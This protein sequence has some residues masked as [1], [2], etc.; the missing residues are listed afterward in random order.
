MALTRRRVTTGVLAGAGLLALASAGGS[1][2]GAL[3]AARRRVAGRTVIADTP[4]GPI[5][6]AVAGRGPPLLMLHGT[7]GG[8]D[9]GLL[10]SAGLVARGF[11][12]I[13]PSRFGYLGTPLPQ[14]SG[15]AAEA[16]A[17][18]DLLDHLGIDRV[19]VAGASAGVLPAIQVALRHPERCTRLVLLVPAANLTGV[20][21]V[22]FSPLQERLVRILLGS[23]L[24]FWTALR[25]APRRLMRTLLATDPALLA[26]VSPGERER[27]RLMLHA[28]LPVRER[29]AGMLMDARAAG[30]PSALD[31]A[32]VAAPTL[33]MSAEDDLFGTAATARI[34]ARRIPSAELLV[35]ED[36]G[37][38]FL[39]R[40]DEMS[41]A[42]AA[43][44][45]EKTG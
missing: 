33:I 1:Y 6:Y 25:L 24:W 29:A 4:S 27:A 10:I 36:G 40:Q 9:Q 41:D 13:A 37:H 14:K 34:L 8:F 45:R 43:F 12:V 16:D 11:S 21:P 26:R 31:L 23:D 20:D 39:G 17:M 18:A 5:E 32:A 15:A 7:G 3:A 19:A 22:G 2:R 28:I 44:L 35:F 30:M 42:V 38:I